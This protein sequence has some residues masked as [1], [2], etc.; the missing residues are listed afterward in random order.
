MATVKVI[1]RMSSGR[2]NEGS[3]Y[4]R[5]IHRRVMRQI[6]TG[7]RI[8]KEEWNDEDGRIEMRAHGGRLLYL[9]KMAD[10][11]KACEKRLRRIVYALDMS[12]R[13]YLIDEIVARYNSPDAVEGFM[14]YCR[15]VIYDCR[16]IGKV[17]TA[18]HYAMALNSFVRFCG[19]DEDVSFEAID[20]S[21]IRRYEQYLL[22]HGL[23][24]NTTSYYMRNLRAMYN[25]AVEEGLTVQRNPFRRVYTGV[26]KT[27]KRAV[28]S[29]SIR[30]IMQLRLEGQPPMMAFARDMFLFSFMTRGM[31]MVDMAYLKKK[32][33]NNGMLTYRRRKTNQ[34]LSVGW[35]EPMQR[36]VDRYSDKD[37][38][39]LLPLIRRSDMD[40]RRQ[41]LNSSHLVNKYLK[42]VGEMIGLAEPL[43][44]YRSRH[45][46]ASIAREHNV[47]VSV[48]S[49]G[50]G[51][52]SEK[53]TRIYL[54]SLDTSVVDRAN[55]KIL[56]KL[57]F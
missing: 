41:Y 54:A 38:D 6:H 9:S 45:G 2:T 28:S 55:D 53:T 32:D 51:H 39:F 35:I 1:F 27:V 24:L 50:M 56:G 8:M 29:E 31:S 43:T 30:A 11:L 20:I 48:I 36:I 42:K 47:P 21:L 14:S 40:H 46:W 3:L 44:M 22:H 49:Q 52:D 25:R 16:Q 17:C 33:V 26:A 34:R 18:S 37:S 12:D 19:D 4:F 10:R 13:E 5:V 23:V 15:K 57:G 7:L